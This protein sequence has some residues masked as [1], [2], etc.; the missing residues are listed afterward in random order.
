MRGVVG[1]TS[2][3]PGAEFPTSGPL[4]TPQNK[5]NILDTNT[6]HNNS[7]PRKSKIPDIRSKVSPSKEI[8]DI[9]AGY[10][11]DRSTKSTSSTRS[12]I[13]A[14][15]HSKIP[16]S[17]SRIPQLPSS[18][19]S[20]LPT[21]GISQHSSSMGSHP[22]S[23]IP[24]LPSPIKGSVSGKSSISSSKSYHRKSSVESLSAEELDWDSSKD[25]QQVIPRRDSDGFPSATRC[26][27]SSGGTRSSPSPSCST[28][29]SSS[30]PHK[31]GREPD[32]A[33]GSKMRRTSPDG[34][35]V[36][37][38]KNRRPSPSKIPI[39]GNYVTKN[40]NSSSNS[41][42]DFLSPSK[43]SWVEE[44]ICGSTQF[45]D[46][47]IAASQSVQ[48]DLFQTAQ[49]SDEEDEHLLGAG[50]GLC[51]LEGGEG[52]VP[53]E[54]LPRDTPVRESLPSNTNFSDPFPRA[55]HFSDPMVP[56]E[57]LQLDI[58]AASTR[59][60]RIPTNV[61]S[62]PSRNVPELNWSISKEESPPKQIPRA[63]QEGLRGSSSTSLLPDP[64]SRRGERLASESASTSR[65]PFL[66]L[67]EGSSG[68]S[69]GSTSTDSDGS[70]SDRRPRRKNYE[71][72]VM[73]GDRMINL[74][75]TPANL[76]FQS[77]YS[78]PQPL[79]QTAPPTCRT[80]DTAFEATSEEKETATSLPASPLEGTPSHQEETTP[81][82][83]NN[84]LPAGGCRRSM[85]RNSRSEDQL[86]YDELAM[87]DSSEDEG[88]VNSSSCHTLL[89]PGQHIYPPTVSSESSSSKSL[90]TG[91]SSVPILSSQ[92]HK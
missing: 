76:D 63:P 75:K 56:R 34:E 29:S 26:R 51:P 86:S 13:S 45:S 28:S 24:T 46:E 72:F 74:A 82:Q 30:S 61:S 25:F 11:S 17:P 80:L 57:S 71:A 70:E 5:E 52:F 2:K 47:V 42:E 22:P 50:E 4:S 83:R 54:P 7:A 79:P 84:P 44:R 48:S 73:T 55:S 67:Q 89:D 91:V 92:V 33:P 81:N 77:K 87:L 62:A 35:S 8:H 20:H 16:T 1:G 88:K 64:G 59:Q 68:S 23:R 14:P 21:S 78:R 90:G 66:P 10:R 69:A 3:S 6:N 49:E 19:S 65:L 60:S 37:P 40:S 43:T 85:V 39:A 38:S 12:K 31:R 18:G 15:S 32:S 41:T 53:C 9:D 58:K 36:S 27:S